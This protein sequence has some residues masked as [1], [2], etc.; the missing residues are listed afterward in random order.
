M[1]LQEGELTDAN[2]KV[3]LTSEDRSRARS[4]A[5]ADTDITRCPNCGAGA[6]W[7]HVSPSFVYAVG[8]IEPRFPR[9]SVEKEFAQ[10][11]GRTQTVSLTDP[12]VLGKVLRE[13]HNRYLVRQLCWVMMIGNLESYILLPRDPGDY[14][15][16]VEALR[17]TPRPTDLDIVIGVRGPIAPREMCNGLLVPIVLFDQIYSFDRESLIK[18]IP[19]PDKPISKASRRTEKSASTEFS[20]A[21]E[22]LFDRIIQMADNAGATDDHRALNYL[23]VRYPSIYALVAEQHG[24]NGSLTGVEVRPSPVTGVR[25]VVD[26][27]FSFTNRNSDVVEKFSVRVDVTEEFPFLVAKLSPFYDR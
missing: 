9:Q 21:A 20:A 16:L 24:G 11:I 13:R 8:R 27:I 23:S 12:Q 2:S 25:T 14:D 19:H 15:L 1:D 7:A 5:Q 6:E 10:A 4:T 22:E 3:S 26:V 18:S 17:A